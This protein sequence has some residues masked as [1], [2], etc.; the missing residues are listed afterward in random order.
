MWRDGGNGEL[1]G[2][3]PSVNKGRAFCEGQC[4]NEYGA[5][6]GRGAWRFT[7]GGWVSLQER[8]KLNDVGA[9]NGEIEVYVNGNSVIKKTGITL[10]TTSAGRIRGVMMHTFFGGSAYSSFFSLNIFVDRSS[11]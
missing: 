1:Y 10:R 2:Y 11:R 8:V 6:L 3:F 9:S 7:S 4:G 5:S